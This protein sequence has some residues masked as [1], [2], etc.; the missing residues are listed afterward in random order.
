MFFELRTYDL[1]PGKVPVYLEFFRTFGV[2]L[3][4]RH[5]PMGGYWMTESGALNRI[6]H[7]WIYD[8]FDERDACRAG[9]VKESAWMD[10]F[11]PRAFADVVAQSTRIMELTASSDAFDAVI[12]GRRTCLEN[13]APETP[14]FAPGLHGLTLSDTPP[15]NDSLAAFRVLSGDRP[16]THVQIAAGSFASLTS[17]NSG[18]LGHEILRPLS[19]SPLR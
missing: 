19:L 15:V 8:S 3:V 10:D 13:Q 4:T 18:A 14:M 11:I 2:A 7:L 16:G 12:A 6:E 5:L 17:G 9:L 1:K